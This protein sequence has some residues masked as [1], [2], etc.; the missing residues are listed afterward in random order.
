[1][2]TTW[3]VLLLAAA[4]LLSLAAP[5]HGGETRKAVFAGGCFWCMEPPFEHAEGV[6]EVTAGYIG[7]TVP[8]PTYEQVT[9][10]KTGHYEA[11][12]VPADIHDFA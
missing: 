6:V 7:G 4:A 12:E 9:G 11:V 8:N 3:A 1:M 2:S 10:G 5:L